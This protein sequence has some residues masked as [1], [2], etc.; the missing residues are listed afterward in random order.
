MDDV[1]RL[2]LSAGDGDRDA[3]AAAIRSTEGDVRRFVQHVVRDTDVDDIVQDTYIR[4]WR[5]LPSYRGDA[6]GRTFILSIARRASVDEIR[7]LSRQRRI[8]RQLGVTTTA[9]DAA[10][11]HAL[12]A[13][14]DDLEPD[15]REAF[16]LTQIMGLSY[17]EAAIACAVP[18]GTIRSRVAR[19]RA[20]M[21]S[22]L[23]GADTR[24]AG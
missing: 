1:G 11:H 2:L 20:D 13:L 14:V 4:L 9:S 22:A 5:A 10:Q 7:R 18:I 3:F 24:A 17:D 23:A 8:R 15:R 16:V 19:A 21:A 12:R 6:S